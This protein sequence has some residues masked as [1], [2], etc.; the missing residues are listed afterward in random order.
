MTSGGFSA[1][2]GKEALDPGGKGSAGHPATS[3]APSCVPRVPRSHHR[4]RKERGTRGAVPRVHLQIII[5]LVSGDGARPST[6]VLERFLPPLA[7][8]CPRQWPGVRRGAAPRCM[9][10][11][12][13]VLSW[14]WEPGNLLLVPSAESRPVPRPSGATLSPL[15]LQGLLPYLSSPND[16]SPP[17]SMQHPLKNNKRRQAL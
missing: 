17:H 1:V 2:C 8:G 3:A 10:R 4:G 13:R 7:L 15:S 11:V 12:L 9:H 5:V 14:N 6:P 16:I